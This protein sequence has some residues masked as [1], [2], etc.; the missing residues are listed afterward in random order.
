MWRH[1]YVMW[2]EYDVRWREY[3]VL[4]G[5]DLMNWAEVELVRNVISVNRMCN[6]IQVL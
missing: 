1:I 6:Y 3:D 2:R 4:G 5:L